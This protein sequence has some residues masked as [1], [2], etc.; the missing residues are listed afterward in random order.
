MNCE[1]CKH[2]DYEK[3]WRSGCE[4]IDTGKM[5]EDVVEYREHKINMTADEWYAMYPNDRPD[6]TRDNP[7]E[8]T[9]VEYYCYRYTK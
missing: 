5:S 7:Y 6:L 8:I 2:F 9:R 4:L 1:E 3:Y